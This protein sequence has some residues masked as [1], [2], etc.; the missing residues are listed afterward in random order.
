[1]IVTALPLLLFV[2]GAAHKTGRIWREANIVIK[3]S[4]QAH[5]GSAIPGLYR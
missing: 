2:A 3:P 4:S 5:D 1:M